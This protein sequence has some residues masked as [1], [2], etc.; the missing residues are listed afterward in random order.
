MGAYLTVS[1]AAALLHVS[2]TTV[3]RWIYQGSLRAKKIKT[4]K[5]ARVLIDRDDI[6]GL[7]V[8]MEQQRS[9]DVLAS[10][11][12]A[13]DT[14]LTL[15]RQFAGRRIDVDALIDQNRQEREGAEAGD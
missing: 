13:V 4:G 9:S 14:I 8:P 5:N 2:P 3:R 6:D 12:A 7:L 10:R 15:Q 11:Q 1:Q